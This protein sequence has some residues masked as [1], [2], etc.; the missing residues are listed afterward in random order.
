MYSSCQKTLN[1]NRSSNTHFCFG[2]LFAFCGL[3]KSKAVISLTLSKRVLSFKISLWQKKKAPDNFTLIK[4]SK[5]LTFIFV[6]FS[7]ISS[8]SPENICS[9]P[10]FSKRYAIRLVYKIKK[11]PS[12]FQQYKNKEYYGSCFCALDIRFENV[13]TLLISL[14][15]EG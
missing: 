13:L 2:F 9:R 14:I 6:G 11:N 5:K 10:R 1:F 3:S 12:K 15:L 7:S 4:E 8:T